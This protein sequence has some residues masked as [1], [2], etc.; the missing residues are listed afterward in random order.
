MSDTMTFPPATEADLVSRV[1]QFLFHEAELLDARDW[2]GWDALFAPEGVYWV[3]SSSDQS[4]P[5]E[6]VSLIY[7]PPLLRRIRLQRLRNDDASSLEPGVQSTHHVSN[8]IV[9]TYD[10][11]A[12]RCTVVSQL[13]V[14]Q[15]TP[16]KQST[17][18]AC[19]MHELIIG[20]DPQGCL[21]LSK[22]IDLLGAKGALG[23]ILT[24]L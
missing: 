8:V 13:I 21:I 2:E 24:I 16:W 6:Q 11:P 4:D 5:L 12:R 22:R 23:D 17:F 7:D 14:G 19:C 3:P 9:K 1:S 15:W 10:A 20:E 18:H